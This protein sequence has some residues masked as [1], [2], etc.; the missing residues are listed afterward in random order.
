MP[1]VIVLEGGAIHV[2]ALLQ[3]KYKMKVVLNGPPGMGW[4]DNPFV[5]ARQLME[6]DGVWI[7]RRPN[8]R[9]T[10]NNYVE[11]LEQKGVK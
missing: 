7:G 2:F 8:H 1:D 11:W 3:I 4:R 10:Y 5:Q 6:A 9:R